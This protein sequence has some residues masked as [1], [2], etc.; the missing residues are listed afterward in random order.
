MIGLILFLTFISYVV[1]LI[2]YVVD[3]TS[4]SQQIFTTRVRL[5]VGIIPLGFIWLFSE[6]IIKLYKEMED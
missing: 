4:Y 5:I 3:I 6:R 1:Q 2:V